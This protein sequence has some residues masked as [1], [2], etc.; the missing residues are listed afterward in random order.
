MHAQQPQALRLN[1]AQIVPVIEPYDPIYQIC[2]CVSRYM[3]MMVG[4]PC[5]RLIICVCV[6]L[7]MCI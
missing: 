1:R 2:V 6:Y 5:D 4:K 7:D 3:H